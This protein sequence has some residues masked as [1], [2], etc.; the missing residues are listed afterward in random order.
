[1]KKCSV[2]HKLNKYNLNSHEKQPSYYIGEDPRIDNTGPLGYARCE[3]L[4]LSHTIRGKLVVILE[5]NWQ[6]LPNL[7]CTYTLIQ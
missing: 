1:M 3:E 2:S 4:A 6:S 7:K 5:S